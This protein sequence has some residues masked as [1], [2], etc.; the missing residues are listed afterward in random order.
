MP[1]LQGILNNKCFVQP[2]IPGTFP[3]SSKAPYLHSGDQWET[4]SVYSLNRSVFLLTA[5]GVS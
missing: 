3:L 1:K 2:V 4:K 5:A